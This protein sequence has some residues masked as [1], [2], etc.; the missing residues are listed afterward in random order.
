MCVHACVCM[1]VCACVESMC[2]VHVCCA[3]VVS[4]RGEHLWCGGGDHVWCAFVCACVHDT[5]EDHGGVEYRGLVA[6]GSYFS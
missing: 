4:M 5:D 1:H 3:C 2:G 6:C